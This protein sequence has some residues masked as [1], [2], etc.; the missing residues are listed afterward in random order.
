MRPACVIFKFYIEFIFHIIVTHQLHRNTS[1]SAISHDPADVI[2]TS[3]YGHKNRIGR[4]SRRPEIKAHG[5]MISSEIIIHISFEFHMTFLSIEKERLTGS[6]ALA[7]DTFEDSMRIVTGIVVSI[8]I[9][10]GVVR[11]ERPV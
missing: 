2:L 5:K 11:L 6:T 10:E 4:R 9:I 8:A 3:H 7:L 1:I